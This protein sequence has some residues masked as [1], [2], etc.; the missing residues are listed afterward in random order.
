MTNV[1]YHHGDDVPATGLSAGQI[2]VARGDPAGV[3]WVDLDAPTSQEAESILSG[4]FGFHPVA[5]AACAATPPQ[6]GL[7]DFQH[8]L[9]LAIPTLAAAPESAAAFDLTATTGL[10]LYLG[11]NY[12]VTAHRQAVPAVTTLYQRLSTDSPALARGS[13]RVA[14]DLLA[15]LACQ[16]RERIEAFARELQDVES[17][18]F[19]QPKAADLERLLDLDRQLAAAT[20][21][22]AHQREAVRQL[23]EAQLA[24]VRADSRPYFAAVGATLDSHTERVADLRAAT[25]ALTA[26]HQALLIAG[27]RWD[28]RWLAILLLALALGLLAMVFILHIAGISFFTP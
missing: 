1:L 10:G 16:G 27:P 8:H 28:R 12:L 6:A 11:S 7:I 20:R 22:V 9:F 3:L 23:T 24:P 21:V 19:T 17:R 18:T 15:E 2:R 26:A 14:A 13:D 5:V 25:A 4:V